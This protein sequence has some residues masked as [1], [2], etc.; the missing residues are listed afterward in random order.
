MNIFVLDEDPNKA[1]RYA[2]D[3]HV[4]KM[5]LESAQ[6]L[7]SAFPDGNAPYK[8]THHNHPCAVWAREREENYEWLVQHAYA[9]CVE[10]TKRYSKRHRSSEVIQWCDMRRPS[11]PS[12]PMTDFPQAMPDQYKNPDPVVAYRNYYMGE[13]ANFAKWK[14][15][16]PH[17]FRPGEVDC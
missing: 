17:W 15:E 8:K 13:K 14:T 3:K 12:G 4:V 10:Y 9:L 5:I 16:V 2:C 6:L 7:C 1:A 11:L